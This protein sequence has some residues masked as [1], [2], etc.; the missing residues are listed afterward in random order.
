MSSNYDS[1]LIAS[2]KLAQIR[3]QG[4]LLFGTDRLK[5]VYKNRLGT[6]VVGVIVAALICTGCVLASWIMRLFADGGFGMQSPTPAVTVMEDP[7]APAT[8]VED[9]LAPATGVEDPLAPAPTI[10]EG[11]P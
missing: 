4:S 9:P 11:T 6:F 1:Q 7:L 8:G 10:E 2:V 3:T 5:R